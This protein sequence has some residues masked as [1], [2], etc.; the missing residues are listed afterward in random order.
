MKT[1]YSLFITGDNAKTK[2]GVKIVKEKVIEDISDNKNIVEKLVNT[3]NRLEVDYDH[4]DDILEN[5]LED[6][7][8]F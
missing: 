3:C 5:Y 6:F 1:S 7:S 2:Y 4:F 8:T